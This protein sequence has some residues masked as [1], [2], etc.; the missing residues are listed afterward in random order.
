MDEDTYQLSVEIRKAAVE[1]YLNSLDKGVETS[2]KWLLRLIESCPRWN[3]EHRLPEI[4]QAVE[5]LK[6]AHELHD[7]IGYEH[8]WKIVE[9]D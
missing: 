1:E 5:D 8:L 7:A 6:D 4:M 9:K 2:K 3:W